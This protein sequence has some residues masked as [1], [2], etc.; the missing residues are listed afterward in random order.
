AGALAL[1][2][3]AQA[4]EKAGAFALVL[5]GVAIETAEEVTG[6]VGVPTIGIASGPHCS[7]QVLVI[8]DMLGMN[9]EFKPTFLK[10][11]ADGHK[12]VTTAVRRY[13]DEV[14]KGR[15]PTAGH[16]FHRK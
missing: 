10:T 14:K 3:E 8:Y 13:V 2:E 4:F 12:V 6:A 11:Y 7:G 1:V 9:P 15:F 16:G 5:E